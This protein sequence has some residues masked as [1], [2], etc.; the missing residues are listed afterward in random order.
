MGKFTKHQTDE[1]FESASVIQL[2]SNISRFTAEHSYS[3]GLME[4]SNDIYFQRKQNN[5]FQRE[6]FTPLKV[7]MRMTYF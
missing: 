6:L 5:I 2:F 4:K 7:I 1:H 3:V